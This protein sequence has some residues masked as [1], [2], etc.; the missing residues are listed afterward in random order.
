MNSVPVL[1]RAWDPWSLAVF[2]AFGLEFGGSKKTLVVA[3]TTETFHGS[4]YSLMAP[5]GMPCHFFF[6][7]LDKTTNSSHKNSS[8]W[9]RFITKI[10]SNWSPVSRMLIA[11]RT[12]QCYEPACGSW[13]KALST[14]PARFL[15]LTV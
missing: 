15:G 10:A 13:R 4:N 14:P 11:C 9:R 8:Y 3:E 1:W 7:I 5:S 12:L 2:G 6:R